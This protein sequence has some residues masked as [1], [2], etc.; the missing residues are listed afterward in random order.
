MD[1]SLKRYYLKKDYDRANKSLHY[2]SLPNIFKNIL[3]VVKIFAKT[4]MK[5]SNSGYTYIDMSV[6]ISITY[7]C[8]INARS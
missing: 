7:L 5:Q 1:R 3:K 4:E 2:S 8:N 6:H